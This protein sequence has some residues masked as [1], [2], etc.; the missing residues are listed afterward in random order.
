MP[1][2][3]VALSY[4]VFYGFGDSEEIRRETGGEAKRGFQSRD[5][6]SATVVIEHKKPFDLTVYHRV[7]GVTVIF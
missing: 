7:T 1:I 3:P 2:S 5:S 6:T 4:T